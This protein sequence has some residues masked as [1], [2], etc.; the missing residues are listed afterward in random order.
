MEEQNKKT[1]LVTG[2]SGYIASWIVKFL[3]EDGHTVHGT[4]RDLNKKEKTEHLF[5]IAENV[6]GELKLFEAD[7]MV[8]GSF[9]QAMKNCEIVMHTASP[10]FISHIKDPVKDLIEPAKFGTAN[11]LEQAN[12]IESIKRI[13][14]TSSVV[15]IYGDAAD[16]KNV[17]NRTFTE[18]HWNISSSAEHQ[19][20]PYSKTVA[21]KEALKIAEAQN[22]WTLTTINPG[23]VL[24]PSLNKYNMGTSAT[25]VKN[26]GDR[27]FKQ[28]MPNMGGVQVDVRDVA[29]AHI[30]A[31]FN[32][33][34]SGRHITA[35]HN[36]KFIDLANILREKFG[37][38]Y[39]FPKKIVPK[40]LMWLLA[41]SLGYSRKYVSKNVGHSFNADNSYSIK[42]LGIKYRPLEETMIDH[43]QQIL[44][45]GLIEKKL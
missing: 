18:E 13:V 23:F 8:K 41:P 20:Y 28:G 22:Q 2:A 43:F 7:L 3:L 32:K 42:D 15:A 19:P 6:K 38:V 45:D 9:K 17:P 44:D 4:V 39:P 30:L 5:K 11:V 25:F 12:E 36:V 10:F 34:V 29:N 14:L 21:E 31:G 16:A 40:F 24:G 37:D 1:I 35:G 33:N 27:T 26:L